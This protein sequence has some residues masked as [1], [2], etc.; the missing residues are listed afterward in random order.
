MPLT[1]EAPPRRIAMLSYHTC[2]LATLGGKKTG[3]MN[4]YVRDLSR[5]LGEMGMEVDIFTRSQDECQ[6]RVKHDLGPHA[7]VIH[8]PAGPEQPLAVNDLVAYIDEFVANILAFAATEGHV[9]DVIHSHYW[10]SGLAAEK[11]RAAW[12]GAPIIH[13]FHTL[14]HLKNQIARDASEY[15]PQSRL[16][17]E[18]RVVQIA[19]RLVAATPAEV[20]QLCDLYDADPAKIVV[21]PPGVDTNHFHPLP[22]AQAK[23]MIGIP[24][25]RKNIL[26]AGR[27]EP[28]K[29]IDT[30]VEAIALLNARHATSLA[31]TCVTIIGGDPWAETLDAEM[32]RLHKLRDDLGL[33]ELVAFAG[34]RDQEILPMYYAAAEMVVMPSHYESFGMVALEAMAMGTPVI[35]SE[36]G[37]LAYVVRDGYNGFLVPRRDAEALAGRILSLLHDSEL[38]ARLSAQAQ[39]YAHGYDW[40]AIAEAMLRQYDEVAAQATVWA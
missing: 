5:T 2:P 25:H 34:A 33:E 1:F 11:L 24:P 13:M 35:A 12:G 6:P 22:Q 26:F 40:R 19:D 16:E 7:R 39:E 28:L 23:Q 18:A 38:R 8:I 37:G 9:Y 17:G 29:G 31:D 21:I 32:E 27:I 30:L 4:V 10:Q 20:A 15:A 3:G 36:V 14:G